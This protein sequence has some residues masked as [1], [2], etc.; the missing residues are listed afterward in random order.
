MYWDNNINEL[1]KIDGELAEACIKQKNQIDLS[2][3]THVTTKDNEVVLKIDNDNKWQH[4]G[5]PYYYKKEIDKWL[6]NASEVMG[7][8]CIALL[9]L[10]S[11]A[12]IRKLLMSVEDNVDIIVFEPSICIFLYVMCAFDIA[13]I[14][15]NQRVHLVV[16]GL[17][18]YNLDV[19][20]QEYITE[21]NYRICKLIS[22]PGYSRIFPIEYEEL[23]KSFDRQVND[24]ASDQISIVLHGRKEVENSIANL[25]LL[26]NCRVAD[27]FI[28]AF[29]TDRPAVIVSAGPSLERNAMLLHS[30]KNR[31]FL[32]AVD[33]ALPYLT[34]IGV[35]PDLAV[36][37]GPNKDITFKTLY[38]NPEFKKIPFA[39]DTIV[40]NSG[41][42]KIADNGVII[43]SSASEYYK[44]IFS[45]TDYNV[46][47]LDNGGSVST[48]ALSLL[49]KW[50]F[51]KIVM[52]GLDLALDGN[53]LYSGEMNDNKALSQDHIIIDGYY[54]DKA[55]T[56]PD[57]K[58]HLDWFEMM[59]RLNRELTVYNATEGGAL[60]HGAINISLKEV[61]ESFCDKEYY[62]DKV[63]RSMPPVFS[64][65]QTAEIHDIINES[66]M[67]IDKIKNNLKYA[68]SLIDQSIALL[69][70]G[71]AYNGKEIIDRYRTISQIID[72]ISDIEEAFFIERLSN[73][74][75]GN[76]LEDLNMGMDDPEQEYRR[77]LDKLRMYF[78]GML[79]AS[80]EVKTLFGRISADE[81]EHDNVIYDNNVS[82]LSKYDKAFA[83]IPIEPIADIIAEADVSKDGHTITRIVRDGRVQYLNSTYAPITEAEKFSQKYDDINKYG[84]LVIFGFS[85]GIMAREIMKNVPEY[86]TVFFYEPSK[87]IFVH[88]LKNFDITDVIR[89]PRV[90][91]FVRGINGNS[92][93]IRFD[94]MVNEAN[95]RYTYYDA[96]P[97]YKNLYADECDELLLRFNTVVQ[98]ER[99]NIETQKCSG[100]EE[101]V[102]CIYNIP[103]L[104]YCN[105]EEEYRDAFPVDVPVVIVSAGPSLRK[106]V[107][108][109]R[110]LKNKLM[111][112][113][114][115]T[116]ARY[117]IENGVRP[118][119]VVT[120]DPH[121]PVHVFDGLK[122]HEL[123]YAYGS[124]SNKELRFHM[125]DG[126]KILITSRC[127]YYDRIMN[128]T[129]HNMY[130]LNS[131]GSVSTV[132]FALAQSWGYKKY[133]LVGQ[134]LANDGNRRY[135]DD[136]ADIDA[137]K[138]RF[139][140]VEGYYGG[141][142][143]SPADLKIYLDWFEMTARSYPEF[144]IINSTEGGARIAGTKQKPLSEI[145]AEYE[146]Y[147]YDYEKI[148]TD[149]PPLFEGERFSLLADYVKGSI[150][151]LDSI[152]EMLGNGLSLISEAIEMINK[153][154]LKPELMDI[155]SQI[156]E[157]MAECANAEE[158]YFIDGV[159]SEKH[160]DDLGDIFE[161]S[162]DPVEEY[163]RMLVKTGEYADDM[164]NAT[165]MVKNM[166][167]DVIKEL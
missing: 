125:G 101:A 32:V 12:E 92:F 1:S 27:Q 23:K 83:D 166:F 45:M 144:E 105:C 13:D 104:K 129:G 71:E 54:G 159:I 133:V 44:K 89:D 109:L 31:L 36:S 40:T 138:S 26:D 146:N 74:K 50:G 96:L 41:I 87:E 156:S 73:E 78:G 82:E 103:L 30:V 121:I 63:F 143:E 140:S 137:Y 67:T 43:A 7:F 106:N 112:I 38:N 86:A 52:V 110:R 75:N 57:Y 15:S 155:G 48:I 111:I 142:V 116:A 98:N 163:K 84:L 6:D 162:E 118:D 47:E 3:V 145:A 8:S 88:T 114:V 76:V 22:L 18:E 124:G 60:I 17:N 100:M 11:G 158:S 135:A 97:R 91:I 128:L 61:V 5:S 56:L 99:N 107:K 160:A 136:K 28:G 154:G 167:E 66:R 126:R 21:S 35:M 102:N 72:D 131:G 93:E 90:N 139:Y 141:T 29:P 53:K 19:T 150:A 81:K 42:K 147:D 165:A 148:I 85:N 120:I 151:R 77:I 115:D 25:E 24:C 20:M 95:Y 70:S 49:M 152:K 16:G 68:L 117:L 94:H 130:E 132:A 127:S 62:Y 108:E 34:S 122:E 157:I 149:K 113:S 46:E 80:D 69:D 14:I 164:Y 65:D 64:A 10:S 2:G 119:I 161:E 37:V 4:L 79:E 55:A 58:L 33:T 123:I 39:I 9:G 51:N 153:I 59:I 134:D